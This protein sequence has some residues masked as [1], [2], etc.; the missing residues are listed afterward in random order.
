MFCRTRIHKFIA[1]VLAKA[2]LNACLMVPVASGH[3]KES[4]VMMGEVS[5]TGE[6]RVNGAATLS[7]N[8]IF[9]GSTIETGPASSAVI[10]LGG[11]AGIEMSPN[12]TLK[13]SFDDK[14]VHCSLERGRTRLSTQRGV[15]AV[16]LTRDG[17]V[18]GGSE[19]GP[20]LFLV[21]VDCGNTSVDAQQGDLELQMAGAQRMVTAGHRD[22]INPLTPGCAPFQDDEDNDGLDERTIAAIL[23]GSVAALLITIIVVNRNDDVVS[24][25]K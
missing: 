8:T 3:G 23:T 22:S 9:S 20:N 14:A 1:L 25:M 4:A 2:I 18:S 5:I 16:V 24:P 6:V 19:A 17:A 10:R 7:G 12:S 11:S 21:S 13:L 15:K